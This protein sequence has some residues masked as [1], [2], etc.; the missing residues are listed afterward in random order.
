MVLC[1]I[2]TMGCPDIWRNIIWGVS[3]RVFLDEISIWI[4]RLSEVLIDCLLE[5][6]WTS[7]SSLRA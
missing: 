2:L 5:Y 3:V 7:S 1:I 6:E 4:S